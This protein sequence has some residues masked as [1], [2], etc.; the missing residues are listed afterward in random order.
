MQARIKPP[1]VIPAYLFSLLTCRTP[2]CLNTVD[3]RVVPP[4]SQTGTTAKAVSQ[5]TVLIFNA[6]LRA[7]VHFFLNGAFWKGNS[8]NVAQ[9]QA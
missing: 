2:Y 7:A 5:V 6:F 8:S 1:V 4:R 3:Q 9:I